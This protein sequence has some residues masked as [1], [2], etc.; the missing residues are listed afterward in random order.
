MSPFC[1]VSDLPNDSHRFRSEIRGMCK[2]SADGPQKGLTAS[3]VPA[4]QSQVDHG[5]VQPLGKPLD[6]HCGFRGD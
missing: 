3:A 2:G 6:K 1:S 5:P 4:I